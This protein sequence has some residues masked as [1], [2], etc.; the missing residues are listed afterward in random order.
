MK[1]T[2]HSFFFD[3]PHQCWSVQRSRRSSSLTLISDWSPA[4]ADVMRRRGDVVRTTL[5]HLPPEVLELVAD[6]V[7]SLDS[8]YPYVSSWTLLRPLAVTCR[9]ILHSLSPVCHRHVN[10]T[11]C[12]HASHAWTGS[13]LRTV[14]DRDPV[15]VRYLKIRD[16]SRHHDPK[17]SFHQLD[18][19]T[20]FLRQV[21]GLRGIRSVVRTDSVKVSVLTQPA[22][23]HHHIA[24]G[25]CR[26][27]HNSN[28]GSAWSI[29]RSTSS[30]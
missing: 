24:C 11:M 15:A 17:F 19:L 9:R 23:L 5:S 12:V 10:I 30:R 1:S 26:H 28:T 29:S 4:F 21:R 14:L 13:A 8:D 25:R 2:H 16:C 20:G 3:C 7:L 22:R 18:L 27:L 6:A